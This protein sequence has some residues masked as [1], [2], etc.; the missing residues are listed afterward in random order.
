MLAAIYCRYSSDRQR[1]T[2]LADQETVCRRRAQAEGWVVDEVYAD[3]AISGSRQDRPRYRDLLADAAAGLWSILL[4]EDLS[5]LSRDE[6]EGI[7]AV[8]RLEHRGVRVIGVSD[9]YDSSRPGRTA[10]RGVRALLSSLYLE[11]LAFRTHRGQEGQAKRGFHAGGLAYGYRSVRGDEGSK[12]IIEPDQAAIVREIWE[13][14]AAGKSP[15]WIAADLNARG[16]PPPR[17]SNRTGQA[18]WISSAIY[19]HPAK[20]TGI[21]RNPLYL[22]RL[23]WNKSQWL[24]D[25]DTGRRVRRERPK[26]EWVIESVPA[27]RIIPPELE[28]R[29]QRRHQAIAEGT[30]T[31]RKFMGNNG[32]T[33]PR[34]TRLF[35]GLLF[36][37]CGAPFVTLNTK[38]YGCSA[39][40]YRG[41]AV[42]AM[43]ST[44]DRERLELRLLTTLREQIYSPKAIEE[45]RQAIL[46]E[47]KAKAREPDTK[48]L[49]SQLAEVDR[50]I[51]NLIEM[52]AN[53]THSP[54]LRQALE[55]AES[56]RARLES[57]LR[58]ASGLAKVIPLPQ[59]FAAAFKQ[60]L[61]Q[62]DTWLKEDVDAAREILRDL[63]GKILIRRNENALVAEITGLYQGVY[64]SDGSG[65]RI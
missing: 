48:D 53:G 62:L 41:P 47:L 18:S 15:R 28:E 25:P 27:L 33:G 51:A 5:R 40:R 65:G 16:I 17:S 9:G 32:S 37:A 54:A 2:S 52:V 23:I 36:C 4:V 55:Q 44:V 21:L 11:D 6:V 24:K 64:S 43:R 20:G 12:L 10:Q 31:A 46:A 3:A 42:C 61:D 59:D 26:S 57:H 45:Y 22:G 8:R 30:D 29:V 60:Q 50:R 49:K 35:S 13:H 58:H 38:R 63:M 7:Q 14:F 39:A 19:G 34:K 1:E 56:Q